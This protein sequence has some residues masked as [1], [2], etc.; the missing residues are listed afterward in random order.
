MFKDYWSKSLYFQLQ[1]LQANAKFKNI[2]KKLIKCP[3]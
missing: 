1:L 3:I 2:A